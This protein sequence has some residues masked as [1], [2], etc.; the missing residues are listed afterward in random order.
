MEVGDDVVTLAVTRH[1][2]ESLGCA[3]GMVGGSAAPLQVVPAVLRVRLDFASLMA[4]A[5]GVNS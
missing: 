2:E 3:F 5:A 4:V 1:L